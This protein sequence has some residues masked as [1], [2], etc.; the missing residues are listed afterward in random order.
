MKKSLNWKSLVAVPM[1]LTLAL[2]GC[3][4]SKTPEPAKTTEPA[5]QTAAPTAAAAK[6]ADTSKEVK[7][8]M[9]LLG[10]K[11]K[12]FDLVYG[13]VNKLL[14][15]DIN[16][17]VDVSFLSWGDWQ[18]KYPLLFASGEDFDL[19]Y[20]ANWA[21][22]NTQATKGG[23]LEITKDMLNQYAPKTAASMYPESYE[24]AKLNGK[25]FMLPMNFKEIQGV[26]TLFRGDLLEKYN[27]DVK[28]VSST[29]MNMG[30][31]FEAVAKGEKGLLPIN[32]AGLQWV[33]FTQYMPK[34]KMKN[35]FEIG[36]AGNLSV[37][38]N[39]TD[40]DSKAV[41]YYDTEQFVEGVKVSAE[42]ANKGYWSKSAVVNKTTDNDAFKNGKAAVV[43]G[44]LSTMNSL[45]TTVSKEHP[46]WKVVAA[47][48]NFGNPVDLKPFIQNGVA[49]NK[50]S[51]NPERALMM[52]D[53]F[54]NDP[55]YFD[56]TFYGIKGKHYDLAADGKS[57]KLLPDSVNFQPEGACPWGWRD[58]KLVRAIE[59]GIP[60]YNEL[61]DNMLKTAITAPL[62]SFNFDD[63]KVKNELA[64]V[65]NV[66][67]QYV[68]PLTF[69]VVKSDVD[70]EVKEVRKRLEEAGSKK[71]MDE[72]NRQ[73]AEFLAAQKK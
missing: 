20:T 38:Y 36:G 30:K 8:K 26:I 12:D 73:I 13:E 19:I 52:L 4:S 17:T 25:T 63:S 47:D 41:S 60:N 67:T 15:Q 3:S 58:D 24:Q 27:L 43:G 9:Y 29:P 2:A 49:I 55:R 66:L 31:Y 61:R 23:F 56:L 71:I 10:D 34:D 65:G 39:A 53:L 62:Q 32:G 33:G 42:W 14:K 22:Y 21:Q 57:I 46:E 28:D 16:A 37:W 50:N 5:G 70:T 51:K 68:K 64:A 44:N 7:L 40:K 69:G 18:Q 1:V 6:K 11:P 35:W 48:T 54:R 72:M 45:Y 59:G